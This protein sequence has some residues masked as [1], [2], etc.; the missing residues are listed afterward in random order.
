MSATEA[1]LADLPPEQREA[2]T[3]VDGPLLVVAGAGSGKTRVITRRVAYLALRGIPPYRILAVTFTNK[4]AGEMRERIEALAGTGGAWVSTFHSL[5]ASMLRIS[6]DTIGLSRNFTIYDRDDQLKTVKEAMHRLDLG[7]GVAQP[8]GVLH[9]ISNAKSGLLTPEQLAGKAAGWRDELIARLYA[10]YQKILDQNAALD[11]DDLLVRVA[12][13]LDAD[14]AFRERWQRRFQY[15][16]IDEYQDTNR[17]QYLIGHRLA[18]EHRNL[19]ATGDPD[20]SIY[21]WRGATIRNILDFQRDYPDAHVVKLERNYRSTKAI[22]RAADSVIVHNSLRHDRNLWTANEQGE[23]VRFLLGPDAEGEARLVVD[24]I[25]QRHDEGR[26][27]RDVAVFYR[28]NAQSRNFE[29]VMVRASVPYR[30]IG[31]VQFYGRQEI[32][33]LVAYLRVCLNDRDDLSLERIIN[34]P[35]RGIGNRTVVRLKQWAVEGGVSLRAAVAGVEQITDIGSRGTNAVKAFAELLEAFR[36]APKRPVRAL[37]ERILKE[38]GYLAWLREPENEE[39]RENIDEF[40]AKAGSFDDENPEGELADFMQDVALVSDVD[41]FD[42]ASDAVT[43]MTLHAAKGLEFPVVFFTG[44]EENLLPHANAMDTDEEVEEERRLC[45]VGF[46]RAK[47]ELILTAAEKRA[48]AGAE[49]PRQPSRFLFEISPE[50]LEEASMRTLSDF[51]AMNAWAGEGLGTMGRTFFSR[52]QRP[53]P[54]TPL[55]A[56]KPAETPRPRKSAAHFAVGDRVRHPEF[57]VGRII[58]LQRSEK[59][60]LATVAMV[61]GGKRVFALEFAKLEKL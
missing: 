23:P 43:L 61:N 37:C 1:L 59:M 2:V 50:A 51:E 55:E 16:L 17:A 35:S 21:G 36:I 28:T 4:A 19:C 44:M 34:T 24:A 57:G 47:K 46:T 33:D 41:N 40:L 42:P 31:A 39:R 6:A 29:E 26:A 5:C 38:S 49:S 27:W 8:A 48:Q 12:R 30:L 18:A 54:S 53:A 9:A 22:L 25:M 3:H 7:T 20:Q 32:K 10:E 45:Y 52:R 56:P 13:L 58:A 11:F 14:Q 60:S 15:L